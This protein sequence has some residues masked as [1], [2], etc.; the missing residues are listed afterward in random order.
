VLESYL[1][2]ENHLCIPQGFL[3]EAII[4]EAHSGGLGGH[5]GR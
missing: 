2:K 1:F 4:F 5:F 3:K